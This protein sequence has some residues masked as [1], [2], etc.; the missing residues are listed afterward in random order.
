MALRAAVR[1]ATRRSTESAPSAFGPWPGEWSASALALPVACLREA[2]ELWAQGLSR[3]GADAP[4][5]A[6]PSRG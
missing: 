3:T 2:G 5:R 6:A 4:N 1:T